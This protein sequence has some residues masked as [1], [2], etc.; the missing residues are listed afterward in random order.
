M[1]A[2]DFSIGGQKA[3]ENVNCPRVRF[4]GYVVKLRTLAAPVGVTEEV[5]GVFSGC[6]DALELAVQYPHTITNGQWV[7]VEDYQWVMLP[8]HTTHTLQVR[9]LCL[10]QLLPGNNCKSV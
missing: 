1:I 6:G 10:D 2:T 5:I 7:T 9:R 4:G 3:W 8:N